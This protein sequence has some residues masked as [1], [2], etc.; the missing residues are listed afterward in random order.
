MNENQEEMNMLAKR[1]KEELEKQRLNKDNQETFDYSSLM[2]ENE[3]QALQ[4]VQQGNNEYQYEY[5]E[6]NIPRGIT[7]E[8]PVID[9]YDEELFPGGPTKSQISAWRKEWDGYDIYIVELLEKYTFVFRTLSRFEYKQLVSFVNINGLQRE[10]TI[11]N[12]VIL[13]PLNYDC[14]TMAAQKAGIPSTLSSIIMEKSGFTK[15]YVIQ[16]L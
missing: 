8:P 15:D 3:G 7:D 4:D 6:N 1:A 16:E 14:T 9:K 13:W 5:N 2:N 12:T 11:C 10:E